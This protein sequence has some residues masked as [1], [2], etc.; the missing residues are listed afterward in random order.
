MCATVRDSIFIYSCINSFM[1]IFNIN[2]DA[3][4]PK[5]QRRTVGTLADNELEWMWKEAVIT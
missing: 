1:Y 4:T 5:P 2:V 3:V